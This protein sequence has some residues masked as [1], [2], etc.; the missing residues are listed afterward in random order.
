MGYYETDIK[1][2]HQELLCVPI[3]L[4]QRNLMRKKSNLSVS[5]IQFLIVNNN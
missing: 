4:A 2:Y 5:Q 3:K 1:L